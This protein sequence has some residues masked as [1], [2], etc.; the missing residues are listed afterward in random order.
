M[1][2]T[3]YLPGPERRKTILEASKVLFARRG[4]HHTNIENICD[5]LGISRGTVYLYFSNR[6]DVL[7]GVLE[8]LHERLRGAGSARRSRA[9]KDADGD[10]LARATEELRASLEAL[11]EDDASAR[12]LL[13]VAP[14]VH[15]DV[16]ALLRRIDE[17]VLDRL[18]AVLESGA[19]D[20]ALRMSVDARKIAV[21]TL[22]GA[23]RL[24]VDALGR[25]GKALD[26]GATAREATRIS[27]GLAVRRTR[28][29]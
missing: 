21:F 16:D 19:R 20:G 3:P 26:L 11:F 17:L 27:F 4:Y 18:T 14:G 29:A 13:R 2:S 28:S 22:G 25:R 10:L 1:K 6:K 8:H 7:L 15:A 9:R 23:Q 5:E 24:V 12:V